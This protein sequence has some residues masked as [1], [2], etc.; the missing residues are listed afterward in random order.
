[1]FEQDA[2]FTCEHMWAVVRT[3]QSF[4]GLLRCMFIKPPKEQRQVAQGTIQFLSDAYFGVSHDDNDTI[5]EVA[6]R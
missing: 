5:V 4:P 2:T 3:N 1:M 6:I